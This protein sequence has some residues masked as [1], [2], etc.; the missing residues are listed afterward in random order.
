MAH[1][2]HGAIREPGEMTA[3]EALDAALGGHARRAATDGTA[4]L[5]RLQYSVIL[6]GSGNRIL[7]LNRCAAQLLARSRG[8]VLQCGALHCQDAME[9]GRLARLLAAARAGHGGMLVL[10]VAGE[11]PL[12][13]LAIPLA[14]DAVDDPTDACRASLDCA[15]FALVLGMPDN[16]VDPRLDTFAD[17]YR[18]TRAERGV[19]ERLSRDQSPFEIAASSGVSVR[20]V[21]SQLS[22]I[23]GKAGVKGQRELLVHLRLFP[24]FAIH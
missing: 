24:P 7:L 18:L 19:L 21:R 3:R 6:Y 16:A 13:V 10:R 12:T 8:L 2:Q 5:D 15:Q 11:P 9:R 23:Y 17:A 4:L 14:T 22:S 20:T 1:G